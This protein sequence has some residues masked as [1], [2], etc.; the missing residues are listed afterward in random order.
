MKKILVASDTH[1]NVKHLKWVIERNKPL[2]MFIF[3]GDGVIKDFIGSYSEYREYVKAYEADKRSAEKQKNDRTVSKKP[4]RQPSAKK[5]T[6]REQ[7]E[8][9]QLEKDL[10]NLAEEKARLEQLISEGNL[11]YDKL[12]DV[13]ERI[14]EIMALSEEKEMRWLELSCR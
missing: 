5:L 8:F 11:P 6:Y 3:C 14:G 1:G 12:K 13:S 2:D 10:E 9:E 7:K 4:E